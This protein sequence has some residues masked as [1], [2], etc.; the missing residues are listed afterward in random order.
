MKR[1][2]YTYFLV[3]FFTVGV[4]GQELNV[5]TSLMAVASILYKDSYFKIVYSQPQKRGREIFGKLVPFGQVWRTGANEATELTA[6]ADINVNG[7]LLKAGTYSLFSI[8]EKD[9]WTIVIN[10]DLGQW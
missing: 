8:P 7:V 6:T 3:L 10:R 2:F 9:K 4:L 5:R 1:L